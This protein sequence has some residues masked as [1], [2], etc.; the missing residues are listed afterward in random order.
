MN[1][2]I[3][4][5]HITGCRFCVSSCPGSLWIP[6]TLTKEIDARRVGGNVSEICASLVLNRHHVKS[7]R[8]N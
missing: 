8:F 5:C 6:A 4:Y 2:M 3:I 1:I 7:Q